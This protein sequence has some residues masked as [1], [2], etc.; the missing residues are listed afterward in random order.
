MSSKDMKMNNKKFEESKES[1]I[2]KKDMKNKMDGDSSM[3]IKLVNEPNIFNEND[4]SIFVSTPLHN[5][6][7]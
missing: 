2:N 4:N 1:F 3:K 5:N 7:K 6:G